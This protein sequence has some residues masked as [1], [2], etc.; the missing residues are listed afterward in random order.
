MRLRSSTGESD[1]AQGRARGEET[2]VREV[3]EDY[4]RDVIFEASDIRGK[5]AKE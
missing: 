4:D 5:R 1:D 2:A 3:R